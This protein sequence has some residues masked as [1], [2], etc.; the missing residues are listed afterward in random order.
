M[1]SAH[2]LAGCR[3]ATLE[4]VEEEGRRESAQSRERQREPRGLTDVV[5]ALGSCTTCEVPCTQRTDARWRRSRL[6]RGPREPVAQGGLPHLR[7]RP[8]RLAP[9]LHLIRR[10]SLPD[11]KQATSAPEARDSGPPADAQPIQQC[12]AASAPQP[13]GR[14]RRE[15]VTPWPGSADRAGVRAAGVRP[16]D[17]RTPSCRPRVHRR[18]QAACPRQDGS[19]SPS[20]ARVLESSSRP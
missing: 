4:G 8:V 6:M 15:S 11:C 2:G 12:K 20:I 17:R 13:L 1:S 7:S 14:R 10:R 5:Q 18:G 19:S 9:A 3:R 16:G